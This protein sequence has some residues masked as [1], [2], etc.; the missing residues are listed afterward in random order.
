VPGGAHARYTALRPL[1]DAEELLVLGGFSGGG[2]VAYEIARRIAANGGRPPLVVLTAAAA[3]AD[4]HARML[5]TAA[6]RAG[7]PGRTG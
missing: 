2:N 7:H 5:E 4:G 1:A 3:D 6:E